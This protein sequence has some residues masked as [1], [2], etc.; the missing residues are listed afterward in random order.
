MQMSLLLKITFVTALVNDQMESIVMDT[1]L[2]ISLLQ[3]VIPL[4]V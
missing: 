4:F 1:P 3:F 2:A